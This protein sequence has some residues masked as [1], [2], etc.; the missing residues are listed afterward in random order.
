MPTGYVET[1]ALEDVALAL[2]QALRSVMSSEDRD[3]L[4]VDEMD[5]QQAPGLMLEVM[6]DIAQKI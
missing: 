1:I 2:L 4:L 6:E 5:T 3:R